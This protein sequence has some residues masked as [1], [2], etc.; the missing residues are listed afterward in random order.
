MKPPAEIRRLLIVRWEAR[1][2]NLLFITPILANLRKQIPGA[3]IEILVSKKY[4]DIFLENPDVDEILTLPSG[5]RALL[6]LPWLFLRLRFR[7]YDAAIDASHMHSFSF[8]N[9]LL[10]FLS[11]AGFRIGFDRGRARG[12]YHRLIPR[13]ADG[14]PVTQQYLT[15]LGGLDLFAEPIPTK[16]VLSEDEIL[17]ASAQIKNL[18]KKKEER[19]IGICLGLSRR[20]PEWS[21]AHFIHLVNKLLEK[22]SAR[23]IVFPG[24][25]E[26]AAVKPAGW[27]KDERLNLMPI[28]PVRQ[29]AALLSRCDLVIAGD[30][31][32]LH[33]AAACG[34]TTLTVHLERSTLSYKPLGEKHR[35]ILQDTPDASAVVRA[36]CEMLSL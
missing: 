35:V 16:C 31:G 21:L 27:P 29:F 3:R 2:G 24:P 12:L 20:Y 28:F 6:Y 19:L 14:L 4:A 22:K 11:G 10:T 18:G 30:T 25:Q 33:L 32:P 9:A 36:A 23:L 15:L 5:A 1:L 7:H 13:A 8:S 17:L 34:T 26:A